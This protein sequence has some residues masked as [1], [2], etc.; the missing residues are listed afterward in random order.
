M[1]T[2]NQFRFCS[3]TCDFLVVRSKKSYQEIAFLLAALSIGAQRLIR[4]ELSE[5]K[6]DKQLS[7]SRRVHSASLQ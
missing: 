5:E 7:H 6:R 2:I 4:A 3:L 1:D